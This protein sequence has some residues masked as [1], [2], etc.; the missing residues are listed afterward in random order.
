MSGDR[1]VCEHFNLMDGSCEECQAKGDEQRRQIQAGEKPCPI[2]GDR[3]K[4]LLMEIQKLKSE[5][6]LI[7]WLDKKRLKF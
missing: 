5:I 6:E 7:S 3:I 4:K 1:L 2:C